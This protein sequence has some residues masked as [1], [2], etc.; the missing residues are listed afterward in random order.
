MVLADL[1]AKLTNALRKISNTTVV[2][3]KVLNELLTDIASALLQSD[4]NI[5]YINTLRNSV[6]TQVSLKMGNN[7]IGGANM[8]KLITKSVVD[9]L[10]NM[11][12]SKNKAPEFTR[13]KQNVVM[14]VGL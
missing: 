8:R 14:F 9:E 13:G 11:L 4:V 3:D 12:S 5:H 2:D 7:D 10:T 6:K 1:G